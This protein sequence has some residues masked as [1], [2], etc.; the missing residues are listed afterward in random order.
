MWIVR[1]ALRRPYTFV[2]LAVLILIGGVTAGRR[3]PSDI[4]PAIDLPVI[5][6]VW[7]YNGM[8]PEEMERRI[9]TGSERFYTTVV[10]GVEHVESQTL[11]GV[12]VI[13]LFFH[14]GSDIAAAAAQLASASQA[15]LRNLPPGTFPPLILRFNATDV[16][17]LQV[18]VGSRAGAAPRSEQELWDYGANFLRTQL[19]TV[20]GAS[21]SLPYGGRTRQVM[22]DLDPARLHGYG[23]SPADV[24]AAINAQNVLLPAG[25]ALLGDREYNV[26]LNS[27]PDVLDAL[28][29]VPIRTDSGRTVYIRDVAHVR[30][31]GAVQTNVVRQDGRRGTYLSV[32]KSGGA[33]TLDVVARSRALLA[34]L[35][36]A[37][38]PGTEVAVLADQSVFV[39]AA[40]AGTITEAVI[41]ACLTALMIL[42][43]LGSWRSTL[44]IA[45]TI[46]LATLSSVIGLAA[47]G[48][49]LNVM[50]LGGLALAVGI[51]VD[52]ATVA[53][54]NI[55]RNLEEGKPLERAILDGAEQIA[56]PTLV[57][58][59]AICIVFVPVYFLPGTAGF[60]FAPLATAVILAMLASYVLSRTLLPTMVQFLL[61]GEA[62]AHGGA[63][64]GAHAGA[65]GGGAT[66]RDGRRGSRV[67]RGIQRVSARFNAGFERFARGYRDALAWALARRRRVAG[68]FA[69]FC[70]ASLVG[71][72]PFVG[73]DF[74]PRVDTGRFILHVRAPAGTRIEATEALVAR[75]EQV[76]RGVIPPDELGLVLSNIGLS[77]VPINIA[78]SSVA[79]IGPSDAE[80]LVTLAE[81][82][83]TPTDAYTR[84]LRTALAREVPEATYFYQPADIVTQVLNFGLPSAIDVQVVGRDREASFRFA[85][86]IAERMRQV[87]GAADVHVHQ[88]A[89]VPELRY[90]VDRE[91]AQGFGLSQRDVAGNL[92]ISL[93]SSGQT[94]P[95]FWLNPRNGVQYAVAVQTPT[96]RM[97]T[98]DDL[99]RTPV[100]APGAA[101]PQLFGNLAQ[102]TRARTVGVVNHYNVQPV[103]NVYASAEGRD[104]GGVASDVDAIL[105]E[106]RRDLP[107]GMTVVLRGQVA[108]M[109]ASFVGLGVGI[110]FAIALVYL[111][112]VVN[113]QSWADP[114]VIIMALPGALAGIAWGLFATGTTLSVPALMGAVMAMGIS[115]ANSILVVAF[116]SEQ[117]QS[118]RT[119]LEAALDAGAARLRPV[120]MTAGAMVI[121]MVPMAL[122][123]GEGGEQNAPLGR[124]VIGGLL[125]AT[126]ATLFLVPVVYAA[127]RGR[128]AHPAAASPASVPP[129]PEPTLVPA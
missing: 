61:R 89:N 117:R 54:E 2:V 26:R 27:S 92:L 103:A 6:V 86:R 20:R 52:D 14:P 116:A 120:L 72:G 91:L 18:S 121:G 51:L 100:V 94:A 127:V 47:L 23:L 22:V 93:S 104:L 83:A 34:G 7:Q 60:L 79:S 55:H 105:D 36:A 73:Q 3:M 56:V 125:L 41:A 44:I 129:G 109:R 30:D 67:T 11:N 53:I 85:Q 46:P 107:A 42:L 114:L 9:V 96:Y 66:D 17:V 80:V 8:S 62:D 118:G 98:L 88:V 110:V 37:H 126:V 38:P 99:A 84:A 102:A 58:T 70:V 124:A 50:T 68:G 31:G 97:G 4:F 28:N 101:E 76:V 35:A 15:Q 128:S 13:K 111:L 123:L 115:T 64:G 95:N 87:P 63:H 25:T 69:L 24:S 77:T 57:A 75:V 33:S 43:F 106:V 39:R 112:L 21:T 1:L 65:P 108:S 48:H 119:A 5:T 82:H 81:G 49:T 10:N 40:L 16:P 19:Q 12:A 32:L 71:L 29:D 113:F 78:T 74:F 90:T 122:G 45:T 59:L